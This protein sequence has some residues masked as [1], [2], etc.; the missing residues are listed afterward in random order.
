[1][2]PGGA[3]GEWGLREGR[4]RGP[5]NKVSP[6]DSLRNPQIRGPHTLNLKAKRPGKPGLL[7]TPSSRPE[8]AR[9][10]PL[11]PCPT[12][13]AGVAQQGTSVYLSQFGGARCSPS[14]QVLPGLYP[15]R[16][17]REGRPGPE[18]PLGKPPPG[19]SSVRVP[20]GTLE[21]AEQLSEVQRGGAGEPVGNNAPHFHP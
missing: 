8:H 11:A 20:S 14:S 18:N 12:A 13:H 1:M 6:T 4:W 10:T 7:L 9:P 2:P 3:G 15:Q 21:G 19:G 17:A 5:R 16:R